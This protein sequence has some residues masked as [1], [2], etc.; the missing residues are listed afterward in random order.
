MRFSKLDYCQYLLSSPVNWTITNLADHLEKVSHDRINRY[1]RQEKLTPRLLWE[2]VLPDLQT[3]VDGYLVFDDTVLDKRY[4]QKIELVR[5]MYSGTEHRVIRGI[6]VVTCLYVLP[7]TGQFWAIDY[8]IYDPDGDGKTKIDHLCEM[9]LQVIH[10]KQ[11][12]FYAVLMDSWYATK[13]VMTAIERMGKVYYCPLKSNR[14]VDDSGGIN[15]YQ[16]VSTLNWSSSELDQ[17]KLLKIRGFPSDQKVKL[18]WVEVSSNRTD[19][20]VTNDL[21]QNSSEDTQKV[22]GVRWKIEEFHREFKQ[23]TGVEACQCRHGRIQRNHIACAFLVWN[24]LKNIAYRSR[25]TIYRLKHSLLS[26]YLIQQLKSP[27]IPMVIA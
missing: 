24:C 21:S 9:L 25:C 18:F 26:D 23:L 6:G 12:P 5:R 3:S 17:G 8:R 14:A 15:P 4:A 2:N 20:V 13:T 19:W 7:S 1:L 10:H 27:T 11:L 22:C 16:A